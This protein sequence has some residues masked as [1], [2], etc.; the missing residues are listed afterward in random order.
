M[1]DRSYIVVTSH[2]A[3]WVLVTSVAWC[4]RGPP[5]AGLKTADRL[6]LLSTVLIKA[7]KEINKIPV[8]LFL[9]FFYSILTYFRCR[10]L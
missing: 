9:L 2:S 7:Q 8:N 1:R 10:E 5:A 6:L 4:A 3:V